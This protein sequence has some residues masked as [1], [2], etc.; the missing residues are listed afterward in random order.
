M[1]AVNGYPSERSTVTNSQKALN[2]PARTYRLRYKCAYYPENCGEDKSG[3]FVLAGR[4]ELR[5]HTCD[6]PNDDR[7]DDVHGKSLKV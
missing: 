3:R 5:D 1:L 7:P 6:E 2:S 4:D